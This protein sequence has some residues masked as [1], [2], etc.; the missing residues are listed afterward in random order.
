MRQLQYFTFLLLMMVLFFITSCSKIDSGGHRVQEGKFTQT[1]I[2]TGELAAVN[3]RA[4]V[5]QR[6]GRYWYN[7]KIIGLLDHGTMVQA[8]DS[9]IQFDP[10]QVQ[11][12]ILDKEN[13][14]EIQKANLEKI[15]VEIANRKS[16]LQ[17]SLRSEEAAFELKKLEIEQFR[18]ESDRAKRIKELEFEQAQIRFERVKKSVG[19][20]EIISQNQLHIQEIRV[21]RIREEIKGAYDVL[22]QLTIYTPIPGIFQVATKRRSRDQIMIGDE[23]SVGNALGNVP[24]L[25][26]MKVN[27]VVNE[28]D[29]MKIYMGQKVNVRL[30]ALPSVI[31]EGEVSFISKLCRPVERNSRL[32]VF[33]VEVKILVSDERLK[34]G[35]TVSCEY[36]CADLDNVLFVPLQCIEKD[37]D[38]YYIYLDKPKGIE[39]MEVKAGP[40]NNLHKVIEA[41]VKKGQKLVPVNQIS[42]PQKN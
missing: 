35:M 10:S 14:L 32:K 3:V 9:V 5:L 39:K 19:Y 42:E 38:H 31:F 37:G 22:P 18:F 41:D 6:Y 26:W 30:D 11:R 7:M 1:I 28:A 2:E 21:A 17:S 34:P 4:F 13:D 29:F 36:I 33:E 23:V 8:G 12:F 40:S 25:T 15:I 16:E 20:Y 27:T 24:D